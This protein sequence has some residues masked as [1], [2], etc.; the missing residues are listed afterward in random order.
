MRSIKETVRGMLP[1]PLLAAVHTYHRLGREKRVARRNEEIIASL[2]RGGEP[3]RLELGAG[4][5]KLAGWT[6]VDWQDGSALN[7]D[8][9]KGL[10]FPSNSVSAVYSSHVLEHF[11]VRDLQFL[12]GECW[13]V[14][15]PG[16]TF[17]AAVPNARIYLDAYRAPEKFAA[18]QFC[19]YQPAYAFFS[20]IDY[21]NYTAYMDG[22][23][24]HMFDE[25]NLVA[26]V[27]EAGFAE[28]GLR[29]F[30]ATLDLPERNF[31]SIYVRAQKPREA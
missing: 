29:E 2:L 19:Q 28:V 24:R 22:A 12:L 11:F 14:L 27:R 17:S 23:H 21:V 30:D 7:L 5:R 25:Q 10:P 20:A 16:G 18:E 3:I 1:Q 8:L 4:G 13:R 9:T 6:A 15:K 31:E 26:M